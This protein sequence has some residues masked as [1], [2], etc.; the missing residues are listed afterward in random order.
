M[1]EVTVS[2]IRMEFPELD[3]VSDARVSQSIRIAKEIVRGTREQLLHATA[4]L[5]IE[6]DSD[7]AGEISNERIDG[8]SS[9]Y[10]TMSRKAP[11]VFWT[12]TSYGRRYVT[13]VRQTPVTGLALYSPYR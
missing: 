13:L 11:D 8:R 9:S 7:F 1:D 10:E 3:Y 5:C 6:Q 2:T 4:H 12:S